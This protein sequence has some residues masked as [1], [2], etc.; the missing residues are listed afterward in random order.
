MLIRKL[1]AGKSE[2]RRES[3]ETPILSWTRGVRHKQRPTR[4]EREQ[5]R[6]REKC[7]KRGKIEYS[8]RNRLKI[9]TK[10]R[11]VERQCDR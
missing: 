11:G 1:Y 3:L 2:K 5:N 8:R 6:K 9:K 7:P 10:R 4:S